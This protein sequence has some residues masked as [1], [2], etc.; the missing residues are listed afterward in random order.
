MNYIGPG[1]AEA[2]NRYQC[3]LFNRAY[4]PSEATVKE[5]SL[6]SPH[7]RVIF[8]YDPGFFEDGDTMNF[9]IDVYHRTFGETDVLKH[10]LVDTLYGKDIT[11]AFHLAYAEL[12]GAE[13][14]ATI[15]AMNR[16]KQ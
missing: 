13:V 16:F 11:E 8:E 1:Q 4:D 3:L 14:G 2:V 7:C 9:R 10:E 12:E 6:E 5:F 15:Y